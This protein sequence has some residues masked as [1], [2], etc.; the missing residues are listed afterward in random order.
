MLTTDIK[1]L[2][3]R[4]TICTGILFPLCSLYHIEFAILY[5]KN[6]EYLRIFRTSVGKEAR[7]SI[8]RLENVFNF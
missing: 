7:K 6:P 4:D 5:N 2:F 8:R 1:I 3:S